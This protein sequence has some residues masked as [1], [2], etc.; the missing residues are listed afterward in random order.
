MLAV[1][2]YKLI[3]LMLV[4]EIAAETLSVFVKSMIFINIQ[5]TYLT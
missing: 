2:V 1:V 5:V 4:N 3:F